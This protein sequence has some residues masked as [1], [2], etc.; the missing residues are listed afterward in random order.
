MATPQLLWFKTFRTKAIPLFCVTIVVNIGMWLERYVIVVTSL[1]RDY[2]P[3]AWDSYAGTAYDWAAYVG[4][5]GLFVTMLCLFI[6]FLPMITIFELRVQH[7][8][9]ERGEIR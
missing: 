2:L 6:R 4:S 1:R 7:H 9:M 3:Q 5:I 8:E